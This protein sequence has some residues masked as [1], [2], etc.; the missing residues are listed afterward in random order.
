LAHAAECRAY[1]LLSQHDVVPLPKIYGYCLVETDTP[2][3]LVM[4]DLAD[5]A[6]HIDN[7]SNGVTVDQRRSVIE[8]LADLHG[9]SLATD[10]PWRKDFPGVE[11]LMGMISSM[12]GAAEQGLKAVKEKYADYLGHVDVDFILK[13][14]TLEK[15]E[16]SLVECRALMPDVLTHGDMWVNN[17]FFAKNGSNGTLSSR[18]SALIDWQVSLQQSGIN[19]LTRFALWCVNHDMRREH[20]ATIFRHYYDR[21]KAKA[22]DKLPTDYEQAKLIYDRSMAV[23]GILGVLSADVFLIMVAKVDE[24]PTGGRRKEMLQR[25]KAGYDDGI[26]FI[27]SNK[28]NL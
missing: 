10:V 13:E 1:A 21:L 6:G 19:D 17:I 25:V 27:R 22:G 3:M 8:A 7:I 5:R 2:G 12:F 15:L 24:D 20:E 9:W 16:K 11:M 28:T 18:V 14:M 26:E 4:E 23:N